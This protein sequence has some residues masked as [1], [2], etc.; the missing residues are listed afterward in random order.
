M[1]II[2]PCAVA[3]MNLLTPLR[4]DVV[5]EKNTVVL[6]KNSPQ[7]DAIFPPVLLVVTDRFFLGLSKS[8]EA[9]RRLLRYRNLNFSSHP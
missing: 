6:L 5:C 2:P 3:D 7:I 4:N 1:W 8:N 9:L